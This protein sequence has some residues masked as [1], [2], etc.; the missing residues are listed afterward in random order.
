MLRSAFTNFLFLL[1]YRHRSK[2]M[3]IYLLATLL[4]ALVSAVILTSSSLKAELLASL[5]AQPDMVVQKMR[6]GRSVP[7]PVDWAVGFSDIPG[8]AAALPRVY[9]AYFHKPDAEHFLLVGIDPFEPQMHA[10]LSRLVNDLD[11]LAFLEKPQM[12]VGNGVKTFLD[13]YHYRD[14]YAFKLPDQTRQRVDLFGTLPQAT[15]LF[16]NDVIIMTQPLTRE[17][18]GLPDTMATDIA[19]EIPNPLERDTVRSKLIWQH[20][21]I[22]I[23]EKA[24]LASEYEHLFTLKSGLFLLLSLLSLAT[25]ALL[26]YQRYAL[27]STSERK[28]I[29][30]LRAVG[31][32]IQ[33]V[34]WLKLLE[35]AIV[36]AAAF[37]SGFLLAYLYV[38]GFDA[39]LLSTLFLGNA[40]LSI[41]ISLQPS[42]DLGVLTQLFLLF[43]LPFIAAILIPVWRIAITEPMEAMK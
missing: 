21:D 22:R 8:V 6:G 14:H 33:H 31:W 35:N 1:I 10:A 43:M 39:P 16:G 19:V 36:L 20:G 3:A 41:H 24:K 42:L 4:I 28:E 9:G 5:K 27:I 23:I 17:I 2:H 12:I 11:T 15:N 40:N 7:I 13:R 30:I 25:F 26:L 34:I 32:S 18:L 29:G 38:F 37:M